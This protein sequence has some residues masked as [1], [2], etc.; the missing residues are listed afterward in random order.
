MSVIERY[1]RQYAH[2]PRFRRR[3]CTVR[4]YPSYITICRKGQ[5]EFAGATLRRS[6]VVSLVKWLVPLIR[7]ME[8]DF[9]PDEAMSEFLAWEE[10]HQA[11]LR[12]LKRSRSGSQRR[13]ILRKARI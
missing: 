11:E 8:G 10:E 7:Q 13:R 4:V 6:D 12:R 3:N 2:A 1:M 9:D 5:Q